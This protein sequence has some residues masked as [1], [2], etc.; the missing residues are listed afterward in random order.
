M[1]LSLPS[2]VRKENRIFCSKMLF[3]DLRR[4][5]NKQNALMRTTQYVI[6]ANSLPVS[7]D[8]NSIDLGHLS[9]EKSYFSFVFIKFLL[10]ILN[11]YIMSY[12]KTRKYFSVHLHFKL[13]HKIYKYIKQKLSGKTK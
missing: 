1:Y 5:E 4:T 3:T 6:T 7:G 8:I 13:K 2:G 12:K 11:Q 10:P 9:R